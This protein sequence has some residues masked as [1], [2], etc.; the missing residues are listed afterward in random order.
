MNRGRERDGMRNMK[1]RVE[2]EQT[3]KARKKVSQ[4]EKC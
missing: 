4:R 2:I 3:E 1:Q